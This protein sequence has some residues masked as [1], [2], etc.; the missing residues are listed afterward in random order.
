M[1][2]QLVTQLF[3]KLSWRLPQ[4]AI[5]LSINLADTDLIIGFEEERQARKLI[6]I[7]SE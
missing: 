5:D 4:S 6:M 7:P 2:L 3:G 1:R